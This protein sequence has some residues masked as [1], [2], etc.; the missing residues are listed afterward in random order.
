MLIWQVHGPWFVKVVQC[1][2]VLLTLNNAC[3]STICGH[4]LYSNDIIFMIERIR[5]NAVDLLANQWKPIK[6]RILWFKEMLATDTFPRMK[7][8][9]LYSVHLIFRS[10][11]CMSSVFSNI[12]IALVS[13]IYRFLLLWG[14]LWIRDIP[15]E[16]IT[17]FSRFL[18]FS[19]MLQ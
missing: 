4:M 19:W 11:L 9:S 12:S 7:L 8:P 16:N 2:P 15:D 6:R 13:F 18:I 14:C 10:F 3:Y 17:T 1:R 5:K